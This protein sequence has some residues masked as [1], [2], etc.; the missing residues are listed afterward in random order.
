VIRVRIAIVGA[1]IAGLASARVLVAAGHDVVVLDRTPDVGGVWSVTRRYPGLK[2]QNSKRAYGF[3][4]WPMPRDYPDVPDGALMQAY[5]QSYVDHFGFGDRIRLN[6]EVIAAEP[7]EH[8]WSLQVRQLS[9]GRVEMVHCN[10]LVIANGVFSKPY[11]PDY[12]GAQHFRSAN[13]RICHASEFVDLE[14]AHGKHVVVVG[15]G[16]SACDI[17]E[18]VSD[19]AASTTVI[20]RRLLWKQPRQI[21]GLG[22]FE[23][24]TLTKFGE[25]AFRYY[26]PNWLERFYEGRGRRLRAGGF[27]LIQTLVT[28]QL[29]LRELGLLPDGP[30]EAIAD[31]TASLATEGFLEK[32]AAGEI[33]VRRDTEIG[34]LLDGP[35][36]ELRNEQRIPA[37]IVL[38]ATGF[39]QEIPFLPPEVV[40]QIVDANGDFRLYRQILPSTLPGLTFAGYNASMLTSLTAEIA[41]VWTAAWLA[42]RLDLPAPS[43]R[44]SH[45]DA[46]LDWMRKR[47]RGRHVR[48]T[49]VGPFD[50]HNINEMLQDLGSDVGPLTRALQWVVPLNPT[51]Y[52]SIA[53]LPATW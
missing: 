3:A 20:A 52:R 7:A 8:G 51:S 22:H 26:E 43:E 28:R 2:T 42:G 19:I 27:L 50:I 36:L 1:G 11:V 17:A 18:A 41:A 23:R 45:V 10:H 39:S 31:S 29:R 4:S 32:V 16:K 9:D 44:D 14:A 53:A 38:C 46:R 6:T 47:T 40:R 24:L 15:Y 35:A 49:L 5:L 13:G 34:R 33:T 21:R 25:A 12:P 37:D 30:F 48:G